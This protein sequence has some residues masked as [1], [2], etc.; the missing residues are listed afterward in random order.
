MTWIAHSRLVAFLVGAMAWY[1]QDHAD[2]DGAVTIIGVYLITLWVYG[3]RKNI[4]A[5]DTD[6]D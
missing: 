6:A 2:F 1:M 4:G 5:G 3:K